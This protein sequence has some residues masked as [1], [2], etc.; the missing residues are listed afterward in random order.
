MPVL[1]AD[2]LMSHK[3]HENA[4]GIAYRRLK[5]NEKRLVW[6]RSKVSKAYPFSLACDKL[7]F[8]IIFC[9]F[10]KMPKK[11]SK[12]KKYSDSTINKINV[13]AYS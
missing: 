8:N 1:V 10:F 13:K 3:W 12:D 7:R 6:Q 5:Y 4:A 2:I 11:L 9:Y